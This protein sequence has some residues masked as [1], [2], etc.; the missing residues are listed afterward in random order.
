M[1]DLINGDNYGGSFST[2]AALAGYPHVTV[3]AGFVHALPVGLSFTG[4]PWSEAGL[5]GLAYAFEQATQARRAPALLPTI[6]ATRA[7]LVPGIA[8]AIPCDALAF[9][10]PRAVGVAILA[11]PAQAGGLA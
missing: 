2:P 3:P 5:I 4:A 9:C 8:Y 10:I 6:G 11:R 7:N 1:T